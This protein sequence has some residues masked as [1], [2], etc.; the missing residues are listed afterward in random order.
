MITAEKSGTYSIL[1]TLP[2]FLLSL[3]G[4]AELPVHY[5]GSSA[6][7]STTPYSATGTFFDPRQNLILYLKEG[8][9]LYLWLG[10]QSHPAK[11]QQAGNYAANITLSVQLQK[12]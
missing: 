4:N 5:D 9:P 1:F 11:F 10:I 6:M 2:S 12:Y 8:T 7:Y 3:S